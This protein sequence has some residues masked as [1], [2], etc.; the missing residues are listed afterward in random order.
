MRSLA[1]VATLFTAT[2]LCAQ[3]DGTKELEKLNGVWAP[4]SAENGGKKVPDDVIKDI[5]LTIKDGTFVARNGEAEGK[6][7]FK[8]DPMKKPM[9]MDML[10]ET[11]PLKG[12]TQ[13]AIYELQNDTLKI[14]IGD[15][16]KK[17]RPTNFDTNSKPGVVT[18]VYKKVP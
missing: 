2:L 7:T 11:G 17:E 12:K 1:V 9:T 16:D 6:G 15:I 18:F 13:V 4:M 10:L 14:C 3:G 5:R 8:I